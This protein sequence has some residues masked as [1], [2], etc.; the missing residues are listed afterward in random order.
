MLSF[1]AQSV[2]VLSSQKQG[3]VSVLWRKGN[4]GLKNS[5]GQYSEHGEVRKQERQ[6][7]YVRVRKIMWVKVK[8]L[9]P[10]VTL[11]RCT[12]PVFS[13][14]GKAATADEGQEMRHVPGSR[15]Q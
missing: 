4:F 3:V 1:V 8:M 13:A 14:M 7:G 2:F 6:R 5:S 11:C 9:P 12:N 10:L 15:A